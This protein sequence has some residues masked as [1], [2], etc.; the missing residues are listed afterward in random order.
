MRV[1]LTRPE[2]VSA[3]HTK[4][5]G[6]QKEKSLCFGCDSKSQPRA[7]AWLENP[8][9]AFRSW[10]G[11]PKEVGEETRPYCSELCEPDE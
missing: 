5:R 8:G 6:L 10:R 11:K 9:N 3:V 1:A 2:R 7:A 4:I